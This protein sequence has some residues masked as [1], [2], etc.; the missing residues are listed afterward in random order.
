MF[1]LEDTEQEVQ[2]QRLAGSG[3]T[4]IHGDIR[5]GTGVSLIVHQSSVLCNI[6]TTISGMMEHVQFSFL[7]CAPPRVRLIISNHWEILQFMFTDLV[8]TASS[9]YVRDI[10][11]I[12]DF[13]PHLAVDGKI[14]TAKV[15]FYVSAKE[16]YPWLQIRLASPQVIAGL[17]IVNRYDSYGERLKNVEIRAGLAPVPNGFK[18]LLTVNKKVGSFPGPGGSG[19][20]HIINFAADTTAQYVTI[21]IRDRS[22]ILQLNEVTVVE[23]GENNS[24]QIYSPFLTAC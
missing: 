13:G 10:E 20:T 1:G 14:S 2:I 19:Q 8:A 16:D 7:M 15:D 4:A 12:R 21:Q 24:S 11:D 6:I 9:V 5:I 23:E 22:A 17:V 3:S 18:G